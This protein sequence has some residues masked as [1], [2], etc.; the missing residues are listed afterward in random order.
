MVRMVIEVDE[1][2][3]D[4]EKIKEQVESKL[5]KNTLKYRE[6]KNREEIEKKLRKNKTP[7]G[8]LSDDE[9]YVLR[10][11]LKEE[12]DLMNKTTLDLQKYRGR[13]ANVWGSKERSKLILVE[14]YEGTKKGVNDGWGW[15]FWRSG[16]RTFAK[17][18]AWTTYRI[19]SNYKGGK[20]E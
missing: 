5:N 20:D 14:K 11:I 6:I 7:F 1:K 13:D 2:N 16:K 10:S 12:V 3:V 9:Q 4:I 18:D 8:L 15:V 17:L 19:S